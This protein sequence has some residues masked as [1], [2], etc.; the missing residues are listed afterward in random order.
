MRVFALGGVAGPILF[1]AVVL[2]CAAL[3]PDYSHSM[4]VMSA[5]G[6]TGGPNALLMNAMGFVP[7]GLLLMAFSLSLSQLVPRTALA[8]TG[9]LLLGLFGLGILA[10]GTF[11]CDLGCSGMGTSREAHLHI[12]ASVLAFVSGVTACGIFGLVFRSLPAWRALSVF[13]LIS[14]FLSAVLLLA[15]NAAAVS[16]FFPGVWQRLFLGSLFV[17]CGV[18]GSFAFRASAPAKRAV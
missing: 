5:L 8:T 13:S 15:F 1:T 3:R 11:S 9:A 18:V 7:T 17:W 16:N 6:E 4:H 10:A 2:I 14:A 12:V